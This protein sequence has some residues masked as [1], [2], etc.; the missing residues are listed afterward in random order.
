MVPLP[1]RK[2]RYSLDDR[3]CPASH[4]GR[5]GDQVRKGGRRD[6]RG[7]QRLGLVVRPRWLGHARFRQRQRGQEGRSVFVEEQRC[8]SLSCK[9]G[10]VHVNCSGDKYEA[11]T[12]VN[13]SLTVFL[14]RVAS[15]E[16]SQCY[17]ARIVCHRGLCGNERRKEI[18]GDQRKCAEKNKVFEQALFTRCP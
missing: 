17:P 18:K 15:V 3:P 7:R 14:S 9:V 10:Y 13:W 4:L 12:K 2:R 11:T 8:T 16:R 6:H 5:L 1:P